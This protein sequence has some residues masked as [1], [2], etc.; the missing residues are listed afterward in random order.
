MEQGEKGRR[1]C[2][3]GEQRSRHLRGTQKNDSGD[4]AGKEGDQNKENNPAGRVL[5][6]I[7]KQ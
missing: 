2:V 3:R 5:S 7:A 6:W 1:G 4:K